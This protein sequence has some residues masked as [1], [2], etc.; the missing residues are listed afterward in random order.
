M[1]AYRLL[2]VG[3][4]TVALSRD[5]R[6]EEQRVYAHMITHVHA[7]RTNFLCRRDVRFRGLLPS[8]ELTSL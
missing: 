1:T 4:E 7:H 6:L 8:L 5:F 2:G 3:G